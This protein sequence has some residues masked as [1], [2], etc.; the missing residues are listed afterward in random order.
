MSRPKRIPDDAE[1]LGITV[2]QAMQITGLCR[3]SI[4]KLL[5]SGQL[6]STKILDRRV[7]LRR[8]LMS[9]LEPRP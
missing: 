9:L 4:Y 3:A 8:S 5:N 1:S 7:V 6:E 2:G